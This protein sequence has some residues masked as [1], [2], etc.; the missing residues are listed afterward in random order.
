[1]TTPRC[2]MKRMLQTRSMLVIVGLLGGLA[3]ITV[4]NDPA[5]VIHLIWVSDDSGND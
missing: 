4:T 3:G 5:D 2:K 1:M